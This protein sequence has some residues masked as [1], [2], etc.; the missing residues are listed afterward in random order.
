[1][2]FRALAALSIVVARELCAIRGDENWLAVEGSNS[3][4][5][6]LRTPEGDNLTMTEDNGR[7]T[8]AAWF[9][10]TAMP[11]TERYSIS[12]D[13]TRGA[14]I[15]AREISRRLLPRYRPELRRV[16]DYNARMVRQ[17]EER[18]ALL[19]QLAEAL[20]GTYRHPEY[21]LRA[22][23]ATLRLATMPGTVGGEVSVTR[24][25]DSVDMT[26]RNVPAPVALRMLALMSGA[27][28]SS[29]ELA[30]SGTSQRGDSYAT[31]GDFVAYLA[32]V[33][34]RDNGLDDYT[35]QAEGDTLAVL[36]HDLPVFRAE[37][38]C[39]V[40]EC[41]EH[42]E[43]SKTADGTVVWEGA[44]TQVILTQFGFYARC[45]RCPWVTETVHGK[46]SARQDAEAHE[47]S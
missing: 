19:T 4:Q 37:F 11:D 35:G 14:E 45:T 5:R 34:Q 20:G 36:A 38:R 47:N 9:P 15:I 43:A 24:K 8:V 17:H 31:A 28:V 12:V 2:D 22:D 42:G 26:L 44:N 41:A 46:F 33:M 1:M 30:Y 32:G 29:P 25:A 21:S 27:S 23:S 13:E 18:G 7:I 39:V 3:G 6:A 16:L 10:A 40:D